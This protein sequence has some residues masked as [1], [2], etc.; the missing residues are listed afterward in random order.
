MGIDS[1][2]IVRCPLCNVDLVRLT[3]EGLKIEQCASCRGVLVSDDRLAGIKTKRERSKQ[4]L[5]AELDSSRKPDTAKRVRCPGCWEQMEK[6]RCKKPQPF[7]IDR[8]EECRL[9]WLDGG[10]VAA[11][12]L[13]Y[14]ASGPGR[15]SRELQRR[16]AEMSPERRAEFER[17]LAELTTKTTHDF[18]G[19]LRAAAWAA[20]EAMRIV[21]NC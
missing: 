14:Q 3:Y 19:T 18:E 11:V 5:E 2:P 6:E 10:E 1:E 13:G 7:F 15:E 16:L 20:V 9:V 4:Q 21:R 17:N 8:C 12:Q